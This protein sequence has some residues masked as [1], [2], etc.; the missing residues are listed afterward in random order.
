MNI[1][2]KSL[3]TLTIGRFQFKPSII[4]TLVTVI[5]LYGLLS[6][7]QW[8]LERAD[9]KEN[10]EQMIASRLVEA[11]VDISLIPQNP[12][13]QLYLP[14]TATGVYDRSRYLLLD[15]RVFNMQAGYN[16][17]TPLR[18]A[19]GKTILVDRGWL[20]QGKN[21]QDLPAI[22]TKEKEF[23]I[24]GILLDPPTTNVLGSDIKEDYKNWP[25]VVQSIN[26]KD[27][28]L[29]AGYTLESKILVLYEHSDSGFQRKKTPI[30]LNMS[31]DRHIGYAVTWFLCALVLF[32]IY[33]SV[34][35]KRK[36]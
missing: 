12:Q 17:Y 2:T 34:N 29:Q 4:P 6:L 23:T 1:L 10:L 11:P 28:E 30:N 26:L 15:N 3:V 20:P 33:I 7:G 27:I 22:N 32:V 16:V 21:R 8:Q 13:Q 19:N 14:V 35:T 5:T 24:E 9:Y 36:K 18:L 31:S 25:A